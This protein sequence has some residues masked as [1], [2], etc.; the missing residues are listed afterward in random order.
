MTIPITEPDPVTTRVIWSLVERVNSLSRV[1]QANAT[2]YAVAVLLLEQS[3][4]T[5][6]SVFGAAGSLLSAFRAWHAAN[7]GAVIPLRPRGG[8]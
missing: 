2:I 5:V 1:E 7:P 8:S 4:E 6:D 3:E